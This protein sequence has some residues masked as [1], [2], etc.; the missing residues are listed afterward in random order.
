LI[1]KGFA[2]GGLFAMVSWKLLLNVDLGF[3]CCWF[4]LCGVICVATADGDQ[5]W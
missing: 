1:E 4:V 3:G 2:G 5:I